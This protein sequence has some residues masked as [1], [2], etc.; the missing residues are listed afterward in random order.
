MDGQERKA[1]E[2]KLI[3][4]EEVKA[5]YDWIAERSLVFSPDSK[6]LAYVALVFVGRLGFIVGRR[7]SLVVVDGQAGS[8]YDAIIAPPKSGG[9]IFDSPNQLHYIARKDNAFYLVEERLT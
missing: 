2:G 6:R 1:Q 8:Q 3:P 5:E 4:W 7:R 9:V